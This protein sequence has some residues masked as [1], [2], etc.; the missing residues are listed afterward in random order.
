[1]YNNPPE[2][3]NEYAFEFDKYELLNNLNFSDYNQDN[4][5]LS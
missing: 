4:N 3:M 5:K 1:M 2:N